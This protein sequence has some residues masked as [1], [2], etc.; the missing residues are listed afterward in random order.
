[1]PRPTALGLDPEIDNPKTQASPPPEKLYLLSVSRDNDVAA[2][3]RTDLKR[4]NLG[5]H[6]LHHCSELSEAEPLLKTCGFHCIFIRLE[7]YQ[8]RQAAIDLVRQCCP[9]TQVIALAGQLAMNQPDFAMPSGV[10]CSCRTEDLSPSL[11]ASLVE[12]ALLRKQEDRISAS[13]KRQLEL[14]RIAGEL[15]SWTLDIESADIHLDE[16]AAK[17]LGLGER[18]QALHLDEL[19]ALAHPDDQTSLKEAFIHS[20]KTRQ[21]LQANFR[22]KQAEA[23]HLDVEMH[24]TLEDIQLH[25]HPKLSGFIKRRPPSD[26]SKDPR[27]ARALSNFL[28]E[29]QRRDRAVDELREK[30]EAPAPQSELAPEPP[31]STKPATPPATSEE[32][33]LSEELE[34]DRST[35]YKTVL[36]RISQQKGEQASDTFPFDFSTESQTDYTP[37]N[38]TA[39]GF[40]AAA[41]RLVDITQTGHKLRVTLNIEQDGAIEYERERGLLFDILRELLTNVVKHAQASECIIALF[42][43]EDDWVLQVEDDGVGLEKNLVSISAPLNQIGLFRIRTKLAIVGGQLDLTPTQPKGLIARARLPVSL[44]RSADAER[45]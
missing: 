31:P 20:L 22:A 41:K 7:D 29:I 27:V 33:A 9:E 36:D 16:L 5:S 32:P 23:S 15:G 4:S 13:L 6:K 39:E 40:I 18:P 8:D 43:D 12:T 45:A 3:L 38:P 28:A 42:R 37:P 17:I 11:V 1:M 34:I 19:I 14:A 25:R 2:A 21:A 10:E 26:K 24:A 30:L 44:D 35:V